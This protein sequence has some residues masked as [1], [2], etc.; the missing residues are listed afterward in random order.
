M[1]SGSKKKGMILVHTGPGKG[2]TTAA[3]GI[4]F[5]ALGRGIKCGVVQF[6]K[7]KWETGERKFARTIPDLEFHVMGLGFTWESDDLDRDKEAARA[8]W[9]KSAEMILSGNYKIIILDEITYAFHYGW[10]ESE[11]VL[12]VLRKRPEDVHVV[13][14]GRNCPANIVEIADLVSFIESR[15]HPH[16]QGIPAQIGIDY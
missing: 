10:L 8:A 3:L 1:S 14:T 9:K 15:K 5:R 6:L 7:G 12:Q 16:E 11:E 2:K 13:I 4:L